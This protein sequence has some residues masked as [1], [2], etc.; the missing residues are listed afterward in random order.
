M[1]EYGYDH[2]NLDRAREHGLTPLM[3]AALLGRPDLIE[4][5]L[6]AGRFPVATHRHPWRFRPAYVAYLQRL[7]RHAPEQK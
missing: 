7:G 6:A 1:D 2:R 5:L 4:A 3:R